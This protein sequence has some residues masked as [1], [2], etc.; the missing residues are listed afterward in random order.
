M[1]AEGCGRQA[2]KHDQMARALIDQK[3]G[4]GTNRAS[5]GASQT[6]LCTEWLVSLK[7]ARGKSH[8]GL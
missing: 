1:N 8:V 4:R 6:H 7:E 2:W 5:A 3:R